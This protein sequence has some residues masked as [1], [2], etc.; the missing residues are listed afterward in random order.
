MDTRS[1]LLAPEV[2]ARRAFM[3]LNACDRRRCL[4]Y[5]IVGRLPG[6]LEALEELPVVNLS[7]GGACVRSTLP[8]SVEATSAARLKLDGQVLDLHVKVRHLRADEAA[9]TARGYLV[10]LEFVDISSCDQDRID[11]DPKSPPRG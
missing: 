2:C 9:G 7:R 5:E 3:R 8:L 4:R 1:L 6:R 11:L 10:G